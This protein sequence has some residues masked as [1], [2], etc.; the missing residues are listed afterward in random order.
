MLPAAP[1]N[2]S[3]GCGASV[4]LLISGQLARFSYPVVFADLDAGSLR[5]LFASQEDCEPAVD[6]FALLSVA[7]SRRSVSSYWGSSRRLN[8]GPTNVT[9]FHI[10]RHFLSRGARRVRVTLLNESTLNAR[11]VQ[12][13][14]SCLTRIRSTPG[15]PQNVTEWLSAARLIPNFER[16]WLPHGRMF[17]MRHLVFMEAAPA[18]YHW[19]VYMREDNRF[20]RPAASLTTFAHDHICG[21]GADATRA[22]VAVDELCSFGGYSDKVYLASPRGA[23]ELFG[24]SFMQHAQ[25]MAEWL[26]PPLRGSQSRRPVNDPMG[27]EIFLRELLDGA[28][29]AVRQLPFHRTDVR[30]VADGK[31]DRVDSSPEYC[32]ESHYWSCASNLTGLTKC[33]VDGSQEE[34]QKRQRQ[35]QRRQTQRTASNVDKHSAGWIDLW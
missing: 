2:A 35:Q 13:A 12:L 34:R 11:M 17:L 3:C 31:G 10:R 30:V 19:F 32:V 29:V 14:E 22:F 26:R 5:S 18:G 1:S 24:T 6:V 28:G 16:R 25:H 21:E 9:V 27:T 4:A 7:S 15:A 23:A 8:T 20:L 33:A